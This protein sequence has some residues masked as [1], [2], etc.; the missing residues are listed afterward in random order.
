MRADA[1]DGERPWV[2][3]VESFRAVSWEERRVYWD[4]N[5]CIACCVSS[6]RLHDGRAGR[7]TAGVARRCGGSGG[8]R[9]GDVGREDLSGFAAAWYNGSDGVEALDILA[10][11]KATVAAL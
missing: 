8:C 11:P 6:G 7:F 9:K 4:V 1:E 2:T 3:D 10:W 5:D